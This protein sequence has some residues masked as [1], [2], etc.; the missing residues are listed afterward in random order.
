MLALRPEWTYRNPKVVLSTSPAAIA[1]AAPNNRRTHS[2]RTR[3]VSHAA[4]ADARRKDHK[5][6]PKVLKD[7]PI[8]QTFSG[9]LVLE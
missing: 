6:V 4:R 7:S 5:L 3:I 1:V 2:W 8:S 9:G